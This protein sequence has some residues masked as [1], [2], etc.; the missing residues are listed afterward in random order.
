MKKVQLRELSE[1]IESELSKYS[2]DV[3]DGIKKEVKQVAEEC[4][5]EIAQNSPKKSGSYAKGWK[6]KIEF[7]SNSDLRM[8]VYNSKKPQ[9][10]HLLEY[11]HVI[12][13]GTKREFGKTLPRAHIRPAEQHAADKLAE[14]AKVV[15]KG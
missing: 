7:E 3:A 4:R 11:G 8:S 14:R 1:A 12:K 13:N 6:T 10:T 5:A 2:D 9:L 15:V